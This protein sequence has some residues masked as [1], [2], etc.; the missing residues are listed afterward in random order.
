MGLWDTALSQLLLQKD[1]NEN[2]IV[3]H[4]Q[5][6]ARFFYNVDPVWC[7]SYQQTGPNNQGLATRPLSYTSVGV[8]KGSD[9]VWFF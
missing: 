5:M 6:D 2:V 8:V 7:H 3:V 1:V 9:L 4:L